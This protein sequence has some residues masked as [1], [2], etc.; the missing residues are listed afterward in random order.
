MAVPP[1]APSQL[2][3]IFENLIKR[4]AQPPS[5]VRLAFGATQEQCAPALAKTSAS[6]GWRGVLSSAFIGIIC[7]RT[8]L[9]LPLLLGWV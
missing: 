7:G 5:A 8:V 3:R 9:A 4:V 2:Y 1:G 6:A